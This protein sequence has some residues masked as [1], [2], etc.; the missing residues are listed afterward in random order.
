MIVSEKSSFCFSCLLLVEFCYEL[1]L[2]YSIHSTEAS[3][4]KID[5]A[6]KFYLLSVESQA[7]G[8]YEYSLTVLLP[9]VLVRFLWPFTILSMRLLSLAVWGPLGGWY[10]TKSWLP[11]YFVASSLRTCSLKSCPETQPFHR[12]DFA[13]GSHTSSVS[14]LP[15]LY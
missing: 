4:N 7:P 11:P 15:A 2:G 13:S 14:A 3:I 10:Y 5:T 1:W 12:L 8:V 6:R 9:F